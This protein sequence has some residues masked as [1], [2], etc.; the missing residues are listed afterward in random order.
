[1]MLSCD[2]Q[3]PVSSQITAEMKENGAL[4]ISLVGEMKSGFVCSAFTSISL[5][6]IGHLL[7]GRPCE[8]TRRTHPHQGEVYERPRAE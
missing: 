2:R 8:V 4:V 7:L 5:L 6:H 1:M 3:C